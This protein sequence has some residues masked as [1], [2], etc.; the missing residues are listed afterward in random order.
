MQIFKHGPRSATW[1]LED[2][3]EVKK[4]HMQVQRCSQSGCE[5]FE[6]NVAEKKFEHAHQ[7]KT[8]P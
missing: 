5:C 6:T 2:S 1:E 3:V 7:G 4:M 8:L